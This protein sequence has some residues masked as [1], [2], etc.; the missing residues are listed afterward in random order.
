M[1]GA[2]RAAMLEMRHGAVHSTTKPRQRRCMP[3]PKRQSVSRRGFLAAMAATS[4]AVGAFALPG[5]A[6]SAAAWSA[7]VTGGPI[8]S[9]ARATSQ[10]ADEAAQKEILM[11]SFSAPLSTPEGPGSVSGAP[12]LPAGFTDTFT[13]RYIDI[14][15]LRLH[16]VI[17]GEGP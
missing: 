1:A 15:E 16:A 8:G 3:P 7:A 11:S 4:A 12:N 9:T 13:S 5:P 2:R 14:G 17:G 6:A 10:R